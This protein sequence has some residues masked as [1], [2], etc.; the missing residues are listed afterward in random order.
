MLRFPLLLGL[1]MFLTLTSYAQPETSP[2]ANFSLSAY[3]SIDR[4]YRQLTVLREG[5]EGI[6]SDK[7]S[8]QDKPL[9]NGAFGL[10]ANIL[11]G[12]RLWLSTGIGYQKHRYGSRY[13]AIDNDQP[14]PQTFPSAVAFSQQVE[15][16]N[17]Y[18]SVVLPIELRFDSRKGSAGLYVQGGPSMAYVFKAEEHLQVDNNFDI[19]DRTK[20]SRSLQ[21]HLAAAVGYSLKVGEQN[22]L[23]LE[24]RAQRDLFNA[25]IYG[26]YAEYLNRTG[27]RLSFTRML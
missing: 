8:W 21:L 25:K 6:V 5:A 11:V 3:G 2:Y 1:L 26:S 20:S 23:Q 12:A 9:Y 13:W 17:A 10:T 18:E 4:T 15:R 24:A 14:Y 22:R 7:N 16:V 19:Y 27:V